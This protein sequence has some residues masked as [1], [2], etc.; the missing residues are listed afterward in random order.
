MD[1]IFTNSIDR[2]LKLCYIRT[3]CQFSCFCVAASH[4]RLFFVLFLLHFVL[5][6]LLIQVTLVL[7]HVINAERTSPRHASFAFNRSHVTTQ[8]LHRKLTILLE[9]IF[10]DV[11]Q[12]LSDGAAIDSKRRL[13]AAAASGGGGNGGRSNSGAVT[14]KRSKGVEGGEDVVEDGCASSTQVKNKSYRGDPHYCFSVFF[15]ACFPCTSSALSITDMV[16]T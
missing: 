11:Y 5:C 9:N 13:A 4:D 2:Y 3:L 16:N 10:A 14:M 15:M 12:W 1:A 8:E 6:V 7:L